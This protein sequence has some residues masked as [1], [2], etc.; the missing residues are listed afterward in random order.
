M[1]TTL[2]PHMFTTLS[3]IRSQTGGSSCSCQPSP[4]GRSTRGRHHGFTL[5]ELLVVIG[6][7]A[8]L[9]AILLPALNRARA[10]AIQVQCLSQLRQIMLGLHIYAHDNHGLLPA[11]TFAAGGYGYPHQMRRSDAQGNVYDLKES[12]LAPYL[13]SPQVVVCPDP[14]LRARNAYDGTTWSLSQYHAFPVNMYWIVPRPDLRRLGRIKG[15]APIWSCFAREKGGVYEAHG[16][17]GRDVPKG[18]NSAMSDGS[19]RW[20]DLGE[21]EGYWRFG[22]ETHFWPRYRVPE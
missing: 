19:A 10:S 17:V 18:M 2:D 3:V 8:L 20:V 16:H 22:S 9:I 13:D 15:H 6:I 21:T 14:I 11:R 4:S 5:V 7:V 12:F 1:F